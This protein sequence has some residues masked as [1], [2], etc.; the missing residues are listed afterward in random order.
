MPLKIFSK[1]L[2]WQKLNTR[3]IL[4]QKKLRGNFLIYGRNSYKASFSTSDF[5]PPRC[6][7]L[8]VLSLTVYDR[9]L[10]YSKVNLFCV[11]STK[12][13]CKAVHLLTSEKF[14][15]E[16]L[17]SGLSISM[18]MRLKVIHPCWGGWVWPGTLVTEASATPFLR[19]SLI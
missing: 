11:C 16:K 6:L 19:P 9:S 12:L 2:R 13:I 17:N 18:C 7:L 1:L 5:L 10:L 15:A 4:T 3:T 8:F 14:S